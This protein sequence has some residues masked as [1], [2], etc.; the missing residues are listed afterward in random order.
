MQPR[1][2][3]CRN[4]QTMITSEEY[5][6]HWEPSY[7]FS[8]VY[9]IFSFSVQETNDQVFCSNCKKCLGQ[10]VVIF[11]TQEFSMAFR[12]NFCKFERFGFGINNT[13]VIEK[14]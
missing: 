3:L 8:V 7:I 4:C 12:I 11:L 10:K 1:P 2:F 5:L 14:F 9:S 13:N 6:L